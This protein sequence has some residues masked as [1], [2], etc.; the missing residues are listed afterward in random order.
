[1]HTRKHRLSHPLWTSVALLTVLPGAVHAT[2]MY[3]DNGLPASCSSTYD[4]SARTC[5]SGSAA[6]YRTIAEALTAAKPGDVVRIRGGTWSE[7]L[8]PTTSGTAAAPIT[9]ASQ[10]CETPTLSGIGDVAIYL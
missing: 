9:I 5:G 2:T 6:G 7:L 1:M 8:V 3:A 4:A 10:T